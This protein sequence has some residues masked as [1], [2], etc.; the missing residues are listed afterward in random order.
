MTR[1]RKPT[2]TALKLVR[3]DAP[4]RINYDE[5]Q[6]ADGV[7]TCPSR[8]PEVRKVWDYTVAQLKTMRVITMADRDILVAYCE[9]V[10]Q[11][12][13]ANEMLAND[14]LVVD[15][16]IGPRAHPAIKIAR[17]SAAHIKAFGVEFGLSP[18]SRTR[19]KVGSS[20]PVQEQ[21]AARLLS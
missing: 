5:P 15:T 20:Q 6:P 7:P 21:G 17:D 9:A 10:V 4:E 13:V 14:G 2:P 1:G 11:H 8:Q 12:H 19:I 18:S 3:G 16:R